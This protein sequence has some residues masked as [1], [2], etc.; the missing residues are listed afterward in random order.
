VSE[1]R[2]IT[3]NACSGEV[4]PG[5]LFCWRHPTTPPKVGEFIE[6]HGQ[7][8]WRTTASCSGKQ[9]RSLAVLLDGLQ[10]QVRIT[11]EA[12]H[13]RPARLNLDVGNPSN[14]GTPAT[15]VFVPLAAVLDALLNGDEQK[16]ALRFT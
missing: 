11:D 12:P 5:I 4:F 15:Q 3:C 13:A 8:V 1:R 9:E 10:V 2:S 6:D 14:T 16:D 7:L